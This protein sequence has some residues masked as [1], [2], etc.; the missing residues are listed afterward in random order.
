[1]LFYEDM[2]RKRGTQLYAKYCLKTFIE[3]RLGLLTAQYRCL[4]TPHNDWNFGY[5]RKIL[6]MPAISILPQAE[7]QTVGALSR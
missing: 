3:G 6:L 1:M 2:Q 7:S 5:L 4:L